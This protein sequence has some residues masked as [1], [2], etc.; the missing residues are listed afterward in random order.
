[1]KTRKIIL[2]TNLWISFLIT[3]NH[4]EIDKLL[5]E[6]TKTN[7]EEALLNEDDINP[8]KKR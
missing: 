5:I 8:E 1:M 7:M 2:D 4:T 3:K 6:G